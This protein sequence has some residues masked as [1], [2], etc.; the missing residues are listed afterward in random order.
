MEYCRV[1]IETPARGRVYKKDYAPHTMFGPLVR[2]FA[3][4]LVQQAVV[5]EGEHYTSTIYPRYE[6]TLIKNGLVQVDKA[7]AAEPRPAWFTL[8]SS[9]SADDPLTFFT[10]E[11]RFQESGVIYRQDLQIFS[12]DYFWKNLQDALLKMQV[13][14]NGEMY[15]PKIFAC[16]DD[17]ANF[18]REEISIAGESDDDPLVELVE[19]EDSAPDLPVKSLGDFTILETHRCAQVGALDSD[20]AAADDLIIVIHRA[21]FQALQAIARRDVQVEQGGMLVGSVT[22]SADPGGGYL[23][24]ITGHIPAEGASASLVE[25]RYNFESWQQQTARLKEQFPGQQIVGWYHTHL[26][27]AEVASKDAPDETVSTEFFFSEEDRF[28]QRQFFAE[29]WYAAMVLNASG[30]AVFFRWFGDTIG[31]SR[32]FYVVE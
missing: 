26:I 12:L 27:K 6:D 23:V 2:A 3:G 14:E 10:M 31:L 29:P 32:Q 15:L 28:M 17:Q 1:V 20:P 18:E 24:A 16:N 11:L 21:V 4:E 9:G 25:L 22:R 5:Q 8:E 19:I 13:L 7:R 30:E